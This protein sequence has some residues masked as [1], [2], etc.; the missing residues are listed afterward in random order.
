MA[1]TNNESSGGGY[2]DAESLSEI[3]TP[4]QRPVLTA[5]ALEFCDA[6]INNESTGLYQYEYS[7]AQSDQLS[8][9]SEFE[10]TVRPRSDLSSLP[11]T[12]QTLAVPWTMEDLQAHAPELPPQRSREGDPFAYY[13]REY[14]PTAVVP[15]RSVVDLSR[16]TSTSTLSTTSENGPSPGRHDS[17]SASQSPEKRPPASRDFSIQ[18]ITGPTSD[19]QLPRPTSVP[20]LPTQSTAQKRRGDSKYP[21]YPDQSFAALQSQHYPPSYHPLRTRSSHPAHSVSY[22]PSS[23][24]PR[25]YSNMPSG[26]KTVGN[27]PAQSPGL[28][29]PTISR[30]KNIGDDSEES[31]Y[32][33]P[34]LHPTHL[35]APK[36]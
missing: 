25:D 22:S 11:S 6:G 32:N 31:H 26:A 35:Q 5:S 20:N 8:W 36:E 29:T 13:S 27:T 17:T 1:T 4:Q 14:H 34:L 18:T 2:E 16:A 7:S 3:E 30:S 10:Q 33:T 24:R 21:N 12:A 19:P 23:S 28:F 9:S 15:N